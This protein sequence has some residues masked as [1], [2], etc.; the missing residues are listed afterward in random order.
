MKKLLNIL[1]F[2]CLSLVYGKAQMLV[3]KRERE[4]KT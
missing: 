2:L 1:L 4:S 3:V